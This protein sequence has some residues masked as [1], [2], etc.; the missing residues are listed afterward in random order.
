MF[1]LQLQKC[2][3]KHTTKTQRTFFTPFQVT[4]NFPPPRRPS[5]S[6]PCA[7]CTERQPVRRTKLQQATANQSPKQNL[8]IGSGLCRH[9]N[10]VLCDN[11]LIK[12]QLL[13]ATTGFAPSMS[14]R[15][16]A[17]ASVEAGPTPWWQMASDLGRRVLAPSLRG[18]KGGPGAGQL[19]Q[20]PT[21]MS[22]QR[23]KRS[24]SGS[25]SMPSRGN[26]AEA[27]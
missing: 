12:S 20:P 10:E 5:F 11:C 13:Q 23:P 14:S 21:W 9:E 26:V 22:S 1:W 16:A 3:T 27:S 25:D 6:T 2:D 8:P 4:T 7:A 17:K 18:P 24:S 15:R 19:R